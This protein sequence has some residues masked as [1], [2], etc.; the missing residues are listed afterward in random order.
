MS[1]LGEQ[2]SA[3]LSFTAAN[4]RSYRDEFNLSLLGSRYAEAG[5][6]HDVIMAGHSHPVKVLPA[7]GIFGANASGKTVL[8]RVMNDLRNA[9]LG[10]FAPTGLG[11]AIA[12]RPFR[13]DALS[14]IETTR[15]AIDLIVDGVRWQYGVEVGEHVVDEYAYVF[16]KGRQSL[17]FERDRDGVEYGPAMRRMRDVLKPFV[18]PKTLLLSTV[19]GFDDRSTHPLASLYRWFEH[20]LVLVGA[21]SRELRLAH[22]ARQLD[23]P[24]R[25]GRA[26][27]LMRAADLGITDI[28]IVEAELDAESRDM[29]R[30]IFDVLQGQDGPSPVPDEF[31]PLQ[32]IRLRHCGRDDEV[33][34]DLEDESQ[35][36]VVWLGLASAVLDALMGGHVLLVDELDASLHPDLV[37]RVVE[38]FQFQHHNARTAQLIFNAHEVEL[39]G[40]TEQR[41]IGRDQIWLANKGGDGATELSQLVDYRPRKDV[42]LRRTYLQGRYGGIPDLDPS[43]LEDAVAKASA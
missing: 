19:G 6:A 17:L 43:A 30:A 37:R 23:D 18:G 22:L 34:L 2:P 32:H 42:S 16:P 8:L 21:E 12:W 1:E 9:V 11:A 24:A 31:P 5:V 29:M 28:E 38:L 25:R 40:D 35:G 15:Y 7:A 20:N 4:A 33:S 26:V 10:S 36:T 3:L 13:L 41:T 39:L 27:A 14:A